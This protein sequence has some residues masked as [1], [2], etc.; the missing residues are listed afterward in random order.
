MT[1]L[2]LLFSAKDINDGLSSWGYSI[3]FLIVGLQSAGVPVP[4]T[5]ALIA[6]ALYAGATHHLD[7]AV[8]VAVAAV[9]GTLGSAVGYLAGRVGGWPL[10]QRHGHRVR[11]TPSRLK[12]GRYLFDRHG[13]KVVFVGRFISGLRTWAAFFAGTN[14][15]APGRFM[16]YAATGAVAWALIHGL[17]YYFFGDV[18]TRMS[19][20]VGIALAIIEVTA[21][22]VL[23]LLARRQGRALLLA[24]QEA[25]PDAAEHRGP[26]P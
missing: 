9:A 21:V 26:W 14:R 7:I 10:L 25:Y 12:L 1:I 8:V 4:G 16:F 2:G 19:T 13:G 15:M 17:G 6:A 24:A 5:S 11:L 3:V 22:T 20:P 23:L 18:L